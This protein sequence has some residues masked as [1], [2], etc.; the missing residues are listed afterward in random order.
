MGNL[1]KE[2]ILSILWGGVIDL[3]V[4]DLLGLLVRCPISA[5]DFTSVLFFFLCILPF[6]AGQ[7]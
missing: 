6:P 1:K 5:F 2:D 3:S 4:S 7:A